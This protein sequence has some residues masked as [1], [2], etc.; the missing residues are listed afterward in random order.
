MG[1]LPEISNPDDLFVENV[2]RVTACDDAAF[3]KGDAILAKSAHE[4]HIMLD[5]DQC[6][7]ILGMI[8]AKRLDQAPSFRGIE[9]CG[10]FIEKKNRGSHE[11]QPGDL[12]EPPAGEG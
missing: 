12:D 6:E 5:D 9:A 7:A 8:G 11:Q 2:G 1:G 3:G 4:I 10:R